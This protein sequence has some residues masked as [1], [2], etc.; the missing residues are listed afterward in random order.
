[1]LGG[2]NTLKN[3]CKPFNETPNARSQQFFKNQLACAVTLNLFVGF[4]VYL[5]DNY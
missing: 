2:G 4:G 3:N 5:V 1:M